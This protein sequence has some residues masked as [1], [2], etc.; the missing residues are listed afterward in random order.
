MGVER[1]LKLAVSQE[2]VVPNLGDLGVRVVRLSDQHLRATYFDTSDLRLWRRR[3]TLRHRREDGADEGTWTLKLPRSSTALSLAR[4]ELEWDGSIDALPSSVGRILLGNLRG[5]PLGT[6]AS[7]QT[8]R[9]RLSLEGSHQQLAELDDDLVTIHGGP[10][11]GARFRQIEV[12]LEGADEAFLASC[13]AALREAGAWVDE[14]PVKIAHALDDAALSAGVVLGPD[15]SVGEVIQACIQQGLARILDH[16]YLLRL[17]SDPATEAIHQTRVAARRLRSDLKS[18]RSLLDPRWVEWTRAEL[19]WVGGTLGQVRDADVLAEDLDLHHRAA[20]AEPSGT[21]PLRHELAVQR[22][23]AIEHVLAMLASERYLELLDTL[24]E[25]A[26]HPPFEGQDPDRQASKALKGIVRGPVKALRK[27]ARKAS[28]HPSDHQLHQIRIRSKQVRYVAE[29]SIPV[30]GARA[31]R[32]AEASEALQSQLGQHHDAV[33]AE[34]W[35]GERAQGA[36]ADVAFVAGRRAAE[37]ARRQE[38]HRKGWRASMKRVDRRASEW[39][40]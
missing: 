17:G 15:S 16:E 4:T 34:T 8:Q 18:F 12:E 30:A 7:L 21:S 24:E 37:Q 38:K 29:A 33:V 25:A 39:L 36:S 35:L 1:E 22:S 20:P 3:I 40:S 2:F 28:K 32:L 27:Q 13:D 9:R 19:K 26:I 6:L 10:H 14:Q 23:L 11:D 5:A 31:A